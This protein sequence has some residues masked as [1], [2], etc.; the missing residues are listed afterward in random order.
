MFENSA[1]ITKAVKDNSIAITNHNKYK[2]K[3]WNLLII[4]FLH[5]I[6]LIKQ[7]RGTVNNSHLMIQKDEKWKYINSNCNPPTMSGLK[8]FII[9]I[10]PVGI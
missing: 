4:I 3:F 10:L 9:L 1:M 5:E 7:I 2:E 8:K 6:A